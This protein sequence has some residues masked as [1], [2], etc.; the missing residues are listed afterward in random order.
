M[1]YHPADTRAPELIRT[2]LRGHLE[3]QTK[4]RRHCPL[5]T[6]KQLT[7]GAGSTRPFTHLVFTES[8]LDAGDT[9]QTQTEAEVGTDTA[10]HTG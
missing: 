4:S 7:P 6:V 3:F 8:V 9:A 1:F 5:E 10:L 2:D